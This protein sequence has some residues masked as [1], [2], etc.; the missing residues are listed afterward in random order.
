MPYATTADYPAVRA[1]LDVTLTDARLPDSVIAAAP[2][3]P[4]AEAEVARR[5]GD[6]AVSA[7][8]SEGARR[9]VILLTAVRLLPSLP[10]VTRRVLG[11]TAIQ[12]AAPVVTERRA[13][14]FRA[15]SDELAAL[16]VTLGDETART[17]LVFALAP[18]GRALASGRAE[19]TAVSS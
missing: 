6:L 17:P 12:Y 3:H 9:A 13:A 19:G 18:G 7:Q 4:A 8:G 15:A 10:N 11:D 1:A 16:R 14:L 2:F 5:L